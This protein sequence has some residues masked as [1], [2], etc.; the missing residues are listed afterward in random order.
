MGAE[1]DYYHVLGVDPWAKQAAIDAAYQELTLRSRLERLRPRT[2]SPAGPTRKEIAAA[3]R[4]LG[5][6]DSR[7]LYNAVYHPEQAH[8]ALARRLPPWAWAV[9]AV[10]ALAIGVVG[11]VGIR[12][13]PKADVGAIARIVGLST[14]SATVNGAVAGMAAPSRTLVAASPASSVTVP[15]ALSPPV[16]AATIPSAAASPATPLPTPA[17]TLAPVPT[18]SSTTA[19]TLTIERIPKPPAPTSTPTFRATDYIGAPVPVNLRS[20]PGT[21]FATQGL[22]PSATALASTGESA[23]AEGFLWRR[24][25]LADGRIGW[26]RQVDVLPVP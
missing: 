12:S 6:P 20:G 4:I 22:L 15:G 23:D 9:A 18:A 26:V 25:R 21:S 16:P 3:Y 10:W 17:A 7:A 2:Q 24:F 8:E 19:P 1:P 14:T 11:C 5:D 13:T